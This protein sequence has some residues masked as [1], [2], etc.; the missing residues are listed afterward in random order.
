[1]TD[2]DPLIFLGHILQCISDVKHFVKGVS[3]EEFVLDKEKINAVVRSVEIIGEAAKNLEDSFKAEYSEIEWKKIIGSRDKI[4]HQY[5]EVNLDIVWDI[6]TKHLL[7]LE[8]QIKK[9]K[10]DLIKR[11]TK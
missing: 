11:V 10:E 9:I 8:N 5:F 2:K 6:A 7:I 4:I 1:M 3:K